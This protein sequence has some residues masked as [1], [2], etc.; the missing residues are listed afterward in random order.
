MKNLVIIPAWN[1][2]E[3]IESVIDLS[4]NNPVC[5]RICAIATT[6]FDGSPEVKLEDFTITWHPK[7]SVVAP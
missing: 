5:L 6:C 4:F 2:V 7:L 3:N 1:E